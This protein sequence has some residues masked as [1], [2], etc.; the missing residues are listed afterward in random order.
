MI[1]NTIVDKL[2]K[3]CLQIQ[4]L[5]END[6]SSAPAITWN[7]EAT[8]ATF[9]SVLP[10]APGVGISPPSSKDYVLFIHS[11]S[12]GARC[13]KNGTRVLYNVGVEN[14]KKATG[15]HKGENGEGSEGTVATGIEYYHA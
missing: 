5:Q 3:N 2:T 12:Q 10:N 8:I 1:I 15:D 7:P 9:Y 4:Q 14:T 6:D 13:L 11:T